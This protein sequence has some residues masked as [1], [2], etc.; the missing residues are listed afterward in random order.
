VTDINTVTVSVWQAGVL[1]MGGLGVLA[2]IVAYIHTTF[3]KLEHSRERHKG[4]DDRF[5]TVERKLE[6]T[7]S[8]LSSIGKDVSYIRGRLEPKQ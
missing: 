2:G 4:H 6:E 8:Q 1:L 3:E 5:G 7:S